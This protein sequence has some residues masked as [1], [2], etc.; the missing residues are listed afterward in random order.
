MAIGDIQH[1]QLPDNL[2]HEPKGAHTAAANTLYVADGEGS[3]SFKKVPVPA[4]DI[5]TEVI[6]NITPSEITDTMVV[7]HNT[8]SQTPLNVLTDVEAYPSI[9][10]QITNK[11]NYNAAQFA[12]MY[13]NQKTINQEI[14]QSVLAL[15]TK[16]NNLL[17]SLRSMGFIDE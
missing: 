2:L 1:S 5:T 7:Y 11:I 6:D 4:L 13:E 17:T 10:Q 16:L 9:P 8:L 15:E 14:K 3:G 12:A